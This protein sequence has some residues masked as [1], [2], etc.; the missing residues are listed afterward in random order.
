[1]IEQTARLVIPDENIPAM[2]LNLCKSNYWV[3]L[4]PLQDGK[5]LMLIRK[6]ED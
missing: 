4:D 5:T 3:K 2:V 6:D 1:M